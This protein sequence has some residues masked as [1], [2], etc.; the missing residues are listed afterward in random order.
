MK[1]IEASRKPLAA[2]RADA[3]IGEAA[4]QMDEKAVGALVVMDGDEA[5]GIVTDRD[6]VVRG[7]AR[8]RGPDA[9]VDGVMTRDPV[10]LDAGDDLRKA[11]PL[12]RTNAIRRLPLTENGRVV[13]MLAL[14]DLLI[15]L[16]AD[17]SDC[18][19]PI[20]GE[21]I[22]GHAEPKLPVPGA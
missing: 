18:V 16:V 13:G 5:V 11:Y 3:S 6:L 15:D 9:R 8:D 4:E 20:T 19:R 2:I 12:F 17:L 21:V 7:L 10:A 1:A 14:D 22:F